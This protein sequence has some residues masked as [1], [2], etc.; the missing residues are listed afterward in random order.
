[1]TIWKIVCITYFQLG[2][3]IIGLPIGI[4]HYQWETS[5]IKTSKYHV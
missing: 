5:K 3:N 1:M 4:N 2:V